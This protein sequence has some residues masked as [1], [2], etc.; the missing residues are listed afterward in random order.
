M[1]GI[2]V[3]NSTMT[4]TGIIGV[5]TSLAQ[6][7]DT[8]YKLALAPEVP[9]VPF[10]LMLF[11]PKERT[12]SEFCV[13]VRIPG[14]IPTSQEMKE[15]AAHQLARFIVRVLI[16]GENAHREELREKGLR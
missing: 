9:H 16:H 1:T 13:M 15:A 8:L 5:E 3:Q 11:D 14:D 12:K 2:G 10:E 6:L 7:T 4:D